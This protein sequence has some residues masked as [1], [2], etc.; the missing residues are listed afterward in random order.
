MAGIVAPTPDQTKKKQEIMNGPGIALRVDPK[1]LP[2]IW[3]VTI[4]SD[5]GI[6]ILT[7]HTSGGVSFYFMDAEGASKF[8]EQLA[9][10]GKQAKTGLTIAPAG[11]ILP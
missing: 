6:V 11:F 8:G 7:A 3:E 2:T 4:D 5:Q 1:P 10:A 9:A